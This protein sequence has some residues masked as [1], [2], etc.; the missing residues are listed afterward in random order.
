MFNI[1]NQF[2]SR[3]RSAVKP[4]TVLSHNLHSCLPFYKRSGK[5]KL[6][7]SDYDKVGLR[8]VK[9]YGWQTKI[10]NSQRQF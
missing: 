2:Y 1:V 8:W 5:T 7:L 3:E 10:R 9:M 6:I 4:S